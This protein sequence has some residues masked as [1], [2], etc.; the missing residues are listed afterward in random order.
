MTRAVL[1]AVAIGLVLLVPAAAYGYTGCVHGRI[2]ALNLA[3]GYC[4]TTTPCNQNCTGARYPY[5]QYNVYR[6]LRE[7][8]VQV[9]KATDYNDVYGSST[10]DQNGYFWINWTST[11]SNP[12]VRIL[13]K[14]RQ[15]DS[16]YEVKSYS[17]G[18]IYYTVSGPDPFILTNGMCQQELGT[19]SLG[20]NAVAHLYEAASRTWFDLFS[21]STHLSNLFYGTWI[22]AFCPAGN[23]P[24]GSAA[25][26]GWG[27]AAT[28]IIIKQASG[29]YGP[30]AALMHELGHT[31]L[32]FGLNSDYWSSGAYDYPN[33]CNF[34]L[35]DVA[36]CPGNP[37]HT[38][39]EKEW[40]STVF[41]EAWPD[42][43]GTATLWS[44]TAA[45][46]LYCSS[47]ACCNNTNVWERVELS[48]GEAQC[49]QTQSVQ[50]SRWELHALR[51]LWDVYDDHD[52]APTYTD[53]VTDY[54]WNFV[55]LLRQI[56]AGVSSGQRN[57]PWQSTPGYGQCD[58]YDGMGTSVFK[59]WTW[60]AFGKSTSAQYDNN[61]QLN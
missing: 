23:C 38:M 12:S 41:S 53:G 30:Q 19:I 29:A 40:K 32:W 16:R 2:R 21:T 50:E 7:V 42:F 13:W 9:V 52:D 34:S 1:S 55:G 51:Y 22:R 54:F 47:S 33:E 3:G 10:T 49:D 44:R 60:Q 46:P 31:S 27:S 35:D 28:R 24:C 11:V 25:C 20:D 4:R 56:P 26:A 37:T 48:K 61:C 58:A 17:T 6:P 8:Q 15:K 45:D 43:V 36:E 18:G 14:Y 5:S 59:T 39:M 57:E